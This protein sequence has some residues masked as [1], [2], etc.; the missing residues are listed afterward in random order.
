[1]ANTVNGKHRG[2]SSNY[3]RNSI[4]LLVSPALCE[5][6]ILLVQKTLHFSCDA[7]RPDQNFQHL[8]LRCRENNLALLHLIENLSVAGGSDRGKHMSPVKKVCAVQHTMRIMIARGAIEAGVEAG[9]EPTTG[10]AGER[11]VA[12][13]ETVTRRKKGLFL[14]SSYPR[15]YSC[16]S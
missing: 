8:G 2:T 6:I 4:V 13:V 10:R 3:H 9:T 1:M 7:V 15:G 11:I 12:T 16:S 14:C 5:C